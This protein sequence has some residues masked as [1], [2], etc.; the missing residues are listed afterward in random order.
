MAVY[1]SAAIGIILEKILDRHERSGIAVQWNGG[2]GGGGGVIASASSE[3]SCDS[4]AQTHQSLGSTHTQRMNVEED[5][6]QKFRHIALID[7]TV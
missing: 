7:A 6:E 2:V 5:S 4:A 1:A 3:R